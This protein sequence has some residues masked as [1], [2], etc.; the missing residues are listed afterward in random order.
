[1]GRFKTTTRTDESTDHSTLQFLTITT[2]KIVEI[3]DHLKKRGDTEKP[4]E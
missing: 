2:A 4:D 3:S 1:M